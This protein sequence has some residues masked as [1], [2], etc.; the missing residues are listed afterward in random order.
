MKLKGKTREQIN[1]EI[2]DILDKELL[3]DAHK[4]LNTELDDI[5]RQMAIDKYIELNRVL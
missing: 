5:I 4:E 1:K 3:N 2:S